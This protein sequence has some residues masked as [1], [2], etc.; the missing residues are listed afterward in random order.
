MC[1]ST[2][3]IYKDIYFVGDTLSDGITANENNIPFIFAKYGYGREQDWSEVPIT[4]T[5]SS[6][7]DIKDNY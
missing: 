6:L 1:T 5:I 2:S 7:I 3:S 4:K